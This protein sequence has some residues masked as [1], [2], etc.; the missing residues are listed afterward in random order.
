[1]HQPSALA[2]QATNASAWLFRIFRIFLMVT[3]M[4]RFEFRW[5]VWLVVILIIYMIWRGPGAVGFV[6]GG[7]VHAFTTVGDHIVRGINGV[8]THH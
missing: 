7:L 3:V 8:R 1:V 5:W 6:L 2:K 4:L